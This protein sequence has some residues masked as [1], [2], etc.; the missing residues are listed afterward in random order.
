MVL[1]IWDLGDLAIIIATLLTL[2][3][4][5]SLSCFK[6]NTLKTPFIIFPFS[7]MPVTFVTSSVLGKTQFS[8]LCFSLLLF[9]HW[10]FVT[11]CTAACHASVSSTVS[12]T[13]FKFMYVES[14]KLSNSLILCHPL[15]LSPSTFPNIRFFSHESALY[16]HTTTTLLTPDV[17]GIFPH[18][19]ILCDTSWVSYNL[20]Q[21]WNC[22]PGDSIRFHKLRAQPCQTAPIPFQMPISSPGY[23]LCFWLIDYKP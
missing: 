18:Q 9:S 13:L 12:W 16:S 7:P 11:P 6:F 17:W 5:L 4:V 19:M 2:T 23:H 1:N 8:Q 3:N 14:V 22:L 15:L 20:T 10:L 21:F